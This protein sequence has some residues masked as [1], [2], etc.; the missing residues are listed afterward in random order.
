MD[1]R[2]LFTGELR[3][4]PRCLRYLN[5]AQAHGATGR[6]ADKGKPTRAIILHGF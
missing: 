4:K 6:T 3:N 5:I 1:Y 2:K